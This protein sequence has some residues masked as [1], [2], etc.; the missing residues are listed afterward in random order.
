M[1]GGKSTV[2][3]YAQSTENVARAFGVFKDFGVECTSV[4]SKPDT[5]TG[6]NRFVVDFVGKQTD[7]RVQQCCDRLAQDVGEVKFEKPL[8][9]EHCGSCVRRGHVSPAPVP[10]PVQCRTSPPTFPTLTTSP[11]RCAAG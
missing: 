9:G 10:A 8:Q 7:A 11:K 4:T 2:A 1:E 6:A 5:F 3:F